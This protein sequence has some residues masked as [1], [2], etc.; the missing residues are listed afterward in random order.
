MNTV[1]HAITQYAATGGCPQDVITSFV[2]QL[3]EVYRLNQDGGHGSRRKVTQILL[4]LGLQP[5]STA[6]IEAAFRPA[7]V[8]VKDRV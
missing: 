6:K 2:S 5:N 1:L 4:E 8:R 7:I 3:H